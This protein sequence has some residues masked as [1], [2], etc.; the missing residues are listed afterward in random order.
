LLKK[1]SQL[2][3]GLYHSTI[4]VGAHMYSISFCQKRSIAFMKKSISKTQSQF[5]SER[6]GGLYADNIVIAGWFVVAA[7]GFIYW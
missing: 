5:A 2:W 7:I 6:K 4:S 1:F 3:R